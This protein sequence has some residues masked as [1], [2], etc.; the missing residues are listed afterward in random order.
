MEPDYVWFPY[1]DGLCASKFVEV[2][3]MVESKRR[4]LRGGWT[5]RKGG[6]L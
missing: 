6:E 4:R 1:G 5:K 3:K 2:E